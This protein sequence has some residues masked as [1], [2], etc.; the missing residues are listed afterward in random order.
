ME[1]IPAQACAVR[2]RAERIPESTQVYIRQWRANVRMPR[3]LEPHGTNAPFNS[4]CHSL[5][6][7]RLL[8]VRRH[9]L[10][11][12]TARVARLNVTSNIEQFPFRQHTVI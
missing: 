12:R 10:A 9:K 7:R 1:I 2:E 5:T 3:H 8:Q 6:V 4:P 11:W